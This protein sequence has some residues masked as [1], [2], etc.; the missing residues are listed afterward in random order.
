VIH[1]LQSDLNAISDSDLELK[2][3]DLTRKYFLAQ[4]LGKIDLLTQ[5]STFLI[6]YK[7]EMNKRNQT[8]KFDLDKDLDQ[9]I[10]VD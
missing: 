9:L 4:R 2:I 3:Q 1:P 10:N 8:K 5:L 7:E 6:I